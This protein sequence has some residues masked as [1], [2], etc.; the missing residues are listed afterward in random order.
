MLSLGVTPGESSFVEGLNFSRS[1]EWWNACE[2]HCEQWKLLRLQ[3]KNKKLIGKKSAWGIVRQIQFC[4]FFSSQ[5]FSLGVDPNTFGSLKRNAVDHACGFRWICV[6]WKL[7][8]KSDRPWNGIFLRQRFFSPWI[9]PRLVAKKE[10]E[11]DTHQSN[12]LG[13][14]SCN[15]TFLK[16]IKA[17]IQR[18]IGCTSTIRRKQDFFKASLDIQAYGMCNSAEMFVWHIT[19]KKYTPRICFMFAALPSL[20]P[21]HRAPSCLFVVMLWSLSSSEASKILICQRICIL[22][23]RFRWRQ[24]Q[25]GHERKC[26][27]IV[28]IMVMMPME[29]AWQEAHGAFHI[30]CWWWCVFSINVRIFPGLWIFNRR[31]SAIP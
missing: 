25:D 27:T 7:Q 17:T 11:A 26:I 24:I 22:S 21:A 15:A 18:S 1:L 4:S 5:F 8:E 10:W 30:N 28:A 19:L 12:E 29:I 6:N 13:C 20:P 16:R 2:A 23:K 3:M 31:K 9:Y 14:F